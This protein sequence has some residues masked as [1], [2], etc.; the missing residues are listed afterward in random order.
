[1][2]LHDHTLSAYWHGGMLRFMKPIAILLGRRSS[3]PD[4]SERV[5]CPHSSLMLM[6]MHGTR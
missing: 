5:P 3:V 6:T 1:M 2:E 4:T